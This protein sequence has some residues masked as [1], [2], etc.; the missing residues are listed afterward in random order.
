MSDHAIEHQGERIDHTGHC[1]DHP[2]IRVRRPNANGGWRIILTNGCPLCAID[3]VKTITRRSSGGSNAYALTRKDSS[4]RPTLCHEETDF[5]K[6]YCSDSDITETTVASSHSSS[7]CHSNLDDFHGHL[8]P[9]SS[10]SKRIVCGM[11]YVDPVSGRAGTYTGQVSPDT[12]SPH[13]V[14][15]LR[16]HDGQLLDGEWSEGHLIQSQDTRHRKEYVRHPS[17]GR[18]ESLSESFN[19]SCRLVDD[20]QRTS[21]SRHPSRSRR[22]PLS[23]SIRF[24]EDEEQHQNYSRQPSKTRR[25]SVRSISR[26]F[27]CNEEDEDA[28]SIGE[29]YSLGSQGDR[30]VGTYSAREKKSSLP[31]MSSGQLD[32]RPSRS[33][34]EVKR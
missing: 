4:R 13:G 25:E 24:D 28:N 32:R 14:G 16:L 31:I 29:T 8:S 23:H 12:Q 5:A 11:R 27:R 26:S 18:R 7:S 19:R 20:E 21:Y 22:E 33:Y 15:C 17:R 9:E 10:R 1:I 6:S 34:S 2:Q 30:T 3:P